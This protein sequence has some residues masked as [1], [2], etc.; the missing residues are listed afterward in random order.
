MTLNLTNLQSWDL[1]LWYPP[2]N[3]GA[4]DVSGNANN[5]TLSAVTLSKLKT[6][7]NALNF[8]TAASYCTITAIN[9]TTLTCCAWYS[10]A[11]LNGTW[12]TPFCRNGGGYHHMLIQTSTKLLGFWNSAF[13]GS[14]YVV[15][16]NIPVYL[17]LTKNGTNEKLYANGNLVLDSNSSF[18]NVTYPLSILGNSTSTTPLQGVRGT[19]SDIMVFGTVL[20]QSQIRALYEATYID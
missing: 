19:M 17:S 12:R 1:R 5:G 8:N 4:Y 20:S 3:G 6:G 16:D 7:V 10:G 15:Q 9:P 2:V 13:Y 18:D 14:T 11:D